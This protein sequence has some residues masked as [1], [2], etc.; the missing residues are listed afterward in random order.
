MRKGHTGRNT[1][2]IFKGSVAILEKDTDEANLIIDEGSRDDVDDHNGN[3][4]FG[5]VM[6]NGDCFGVWL[7]FKHQ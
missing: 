1:Y 7:N 6:R 3:S 4:K 2:V 5:A